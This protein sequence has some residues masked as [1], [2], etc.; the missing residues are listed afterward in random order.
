VILLLKPTFLPPLSLLVLSSI[1]TLF[2]SR[3][4]V[5]G[6]L[7]SPHPSRLSFCPAIS[8]SSFPTYNRI[9]SLYIDHRSLSSVC[10]RSLNHPPPLYT[11]STD[12]RVAC[13]ASTPVSQSPFSNYHH[14]TQ[15]ITLATLAPPP[16]LRSFTS[17]PGTRLISLCLRFSFPASLSRSLSVSPSL[18]LLLHLSLESHFVP[19]RSCTLHRQIVP[20]IVG[21]SYCYLST[22]KKV[23]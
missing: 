10:T 2:I 19:S 12:P 7:F 15:P 20:T 8:L 4:F 17:V 14:F 6:E 13:S 9:V 1:R 18:S 11:C 21:W 23:I 3:G 22:N 16:Y 5:S